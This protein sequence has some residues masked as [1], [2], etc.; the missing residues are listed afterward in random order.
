M[1]TKL[2]IDVRGGIIEVEGEE[3]FVKSIYEEHKE[4]LFANAKPQ[5]KQ[6]TGGQIKPDENDTGIGGGTDGKLLSE[7]GT[8]GDV[9]GDIENF[10]D[11]G[12]DDR[13]LIA[14]AL[15]Q[16]KSGTQSFVG[17]P[18]NK[19]LANAG[20]RS[21]RI[22]HDLEANM[23]MKPARI[24]QLRKSGKSQQARKT[25]KVTT[26]GFKAVSRFLTGISNEDTK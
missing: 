16:T 21:R 26:E 7:Y 4:R 15:V 25:Y 12:S 18:V 2:K 19:E 23:A 1:N 11:L 22:N 10:K 3:S 17:H 24:V 9:F 13:A 20:Y 5:D 14:A 6:Q 8:V